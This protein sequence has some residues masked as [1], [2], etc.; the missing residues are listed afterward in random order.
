MANSPSIRELLGQVANDAVRLGKAQ[1]ALVQTEL[2]ASTDAVTKTGAFFM[3]AAMMGLFGFIFILVTIAYVFVQLGLPTWAG[4][5]IVALLLIIVAAIFA[6]AG[7]AQ[8]QKVKAP[9]VA[10]QEFE[11]TKKT[12]LPDSNA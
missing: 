3:V 11:T 2:K 6:L 1:L 9:I 8:A 7:R 4:F 12:F 5:G 10:L